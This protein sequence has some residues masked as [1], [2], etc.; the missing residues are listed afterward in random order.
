[1]AQVGNTRMDFQIERSI[2]RITAD[3]P[4]GLSSEAFGQSIHS[5]VKNLILIFG[6]PYNFRLF[7]LAKSE[8]HLC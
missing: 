8:I 5:K 1:M 6:L 2:H 4:V 3:T 7:A